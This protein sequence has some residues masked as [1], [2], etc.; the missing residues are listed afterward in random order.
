MALQ[1]TQLLDV[2][3]VTG[4]NT[5]GIFTVGVTPTAGGAGVA[6]VT[7]LRSAVIHNTGVATCRVGLYINNNTYP[8]TGWGVT[9]SRMLRVDMAA[10]ET[11]F[12]ETNYPIVLTHHDSISIDVTAP[13]EGGIGVGSAVNILLNGDTDI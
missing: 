8:I 3:T 6:S 9:A 13:D 4:I 10:N 11:V 12:F 5:V 2:T 7:Y 1:K